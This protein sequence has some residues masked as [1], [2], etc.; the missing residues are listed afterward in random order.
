KSIP[1]AREAV[2]ILPVHDLEADE[3]A[4]G[5]V[6][7]GHV[8]IDQL[9]RVVP[10]ECRM[11][12]LLALVALGDKRVIVQHQDF[13]LDGGLRLF[14]AGSIRMQMGSEDRDKKQYGQRAHWLAFQW[15]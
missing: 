14:L 12:R 5:L 9:A 2:Q 8:S 15:Q 7:V 4:G 13:D 6:E 3:P 1:L 11:Q 10:L